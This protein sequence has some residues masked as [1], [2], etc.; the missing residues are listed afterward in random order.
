[1]THPIP[2]SESSPTP[3]HMHMPSVKN[4][5]I[6]MFHQWP[7]LKTKALFFIN[8]NPLNGSRYQLAV[9]KFCV[10]VFVGHGFQ[11]LHRGMPRAFST[12]L[13]GFLPPMIMSNLNIRSFTLGGGGGGGG[14]IYLNLLY[15]T[16][17]FFM[18]CNHETHFGCCHITELTTHSLRMMND[19]NHA[20]IP[21]S[22]GCPRAYVMQNVNACISCYM[23]NEHYMK[24]FINRTLYQVPWIIIFNTYNLHPF[25]LIY[26]THTYQHIQHFI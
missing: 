20:H 6:I 22:M 25:M 9:L 3:S 13:I 21:N 4:R 10:Y 16:H 1:M 19:H 24:Q 2:S 7:F 26:I 17:V 11:G 14:E 8:Q 5:T 12:F 23:Y 15:P 18:L